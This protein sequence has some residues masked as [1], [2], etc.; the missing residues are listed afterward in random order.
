VLLVNPPDMT[1]LVDTSCFTRNAYCPGM[2]ELRAFASNTPSSL[3]MALVERKMSSA[4]NVEDADLNASN[5][6]F[7]SS[8]AAFDAFSPPMRWKM[9]VFAW[10]SSARSC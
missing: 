10:A 2:A 1:W 6:A 7:T 9:G 3:D 5:R 8:K 4:R